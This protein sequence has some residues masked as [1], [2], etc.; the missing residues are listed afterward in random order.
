MG[1]VFKG[2]IMGI[3]ASG[4]ILVAIRIAF[5]KQPQVIQTYGDG[6]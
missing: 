1:P 3:A 5:P 6:A 2:F 4:L